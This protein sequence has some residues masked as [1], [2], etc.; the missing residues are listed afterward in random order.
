MSGFNY[1]LVISNIAQLSITLPDGLPLVIADAQPSAPCPLPA[2]FP[3]RNP[4]IELTD[5]A[6]FSAFRAG[7]KQIYRSAYMIN[8]V[9]LHKLLDQSVDYSQYDPVIRQT[10]KIVFTEV[11]R[12]ATQLGVDR[13]LPGRASIDGNI[14]GV[15]KRTYLGALISF[16]CI[17]NFKLG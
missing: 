7:A 10:I 17:E 3:S 9:Y 11:T 16:T 4:S 14:L 8:Y 6:P 13:V 15:D 5:L 12:H 2:L 1:D